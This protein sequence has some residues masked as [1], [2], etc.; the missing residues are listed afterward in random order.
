MRRA[1]RDVRLVAHG[2]VARVNGARLVGAVVAAGSQAARLQQTKHSHRHLR[3]SHYCSFE[4]TK[5]YMSR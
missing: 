3:A 5:C 1:E 4:C 2:G